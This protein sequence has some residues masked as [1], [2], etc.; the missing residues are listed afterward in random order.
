[1]TAAPYGL[2]QSSVKGLAVDQNTALTVDPSGQAQVW[3]AGDAYFAYASSAPTLTQGT[4]AGQAALQ[5]SG[6]QM[7]WKNCDSNAFSLALAWNAQPLAIFSVVGTN[8]PGNQIILTAGTW[9]T[10]IFP[11]PPPQN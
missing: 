4:S 5:F 10:T 8:A 3:G 7:S 11:G 6:V 9:P 1:M 2:G